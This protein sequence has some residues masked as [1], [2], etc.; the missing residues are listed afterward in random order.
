ML[1]GHRANPDTGCVGCPV[2][3]GTVLTLTQTRGKALKRNMRSGFTLVEL[4]V[5]IGILGLLVGI[6]AVAVIPKLTEAKNKLEIKQLGDIKTAFDNISIDKSKA[7]L[8]QKAPLKEARGRKFYEAAFKKK[9]LNDDLVGKIVSLN[10][11]DTSADKAFITDENMEL[12]ELN[13]SYTAPIGGELLVLMKK[14]G[15]L[16]KVLITFN[17]RN[18]L[19]YADHGTIIQF[20][21]GETA[22]YM[23]KDT[24]ATEYQI[25]ADTWDTNAGDIIGNKPPFDKTYE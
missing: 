11:G 21:D 16:R 22:D 19:N 6:L 9:L 23:N 5:V 7:G 2:K 10:S 20:S 14:T 4:M 18:W 25:D 13:C 8:L 12:G 1:D 24:A 17:A 3:L 15:K